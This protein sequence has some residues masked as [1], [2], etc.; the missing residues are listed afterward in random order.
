MDVTLQ[1][2]ARCCASSK[3]PYRVHSSSNATGWKLAI[4]T[5]TR[6]PLECFLREGSGRVFGAAIAELARVMQQGILP[7]GYLASRV[8]DQRML[9]IRD[10]E[11]KGQRADPTDQH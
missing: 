10:R 9:P 5:S 4:V 11:R 6:K 2:P 7:N 3:P 8:L 1:E